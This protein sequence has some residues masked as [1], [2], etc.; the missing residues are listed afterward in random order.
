MIT[1]IKKK[2]AQI[3]VIKNQIA[4]NKCK[5]YFAAKNKIK[6]L[7]NHL[8]DLHTAYENEKKQLTS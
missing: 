4:A 5:N 6:T 1:E 2:E 7:E 3:A 8:A